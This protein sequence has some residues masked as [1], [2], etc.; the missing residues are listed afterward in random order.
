VDGVTAAL[1]KVCHE[2][3]RGLAV[4]AQPATFTCFTVL[5]YL[6]SIKRPKLTHHCFLHEVGLLTKLTN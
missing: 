2:R 3:A 4:L 5:T 6:P 1:M